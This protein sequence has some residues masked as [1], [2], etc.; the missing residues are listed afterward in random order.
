M[1]PIIQELLSKGS[2]ELSTCVEAG[3]GLLVP[4]TI[5]GPGGLVL[6]RCCGRSDTLTWKDRVRDGR[7]DYWEPLH[8]GLGSAPKEGLTGVPLEG[9]PGRVAWKA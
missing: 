7:P 5:P 4:P 9:T 8:Q 1:Q 2:R 3:L 6:S